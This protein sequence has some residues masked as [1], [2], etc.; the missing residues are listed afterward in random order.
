MWG[1]YTCELDWA[2]VPAAINNEP[3]CTEPCVWARF[4]A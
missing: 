3:P 4:Y 2:K 1:R